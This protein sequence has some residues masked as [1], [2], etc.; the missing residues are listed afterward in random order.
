MVLFILL[1][2]TYILLISPRPW[3][4]SRMGLSHFVQDKRHSPGAQLVHNKHRQSADV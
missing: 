1:A 4:L 3:D 2:S